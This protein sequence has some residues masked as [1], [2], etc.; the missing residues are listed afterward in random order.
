MHLTNLTEEEKT[1]IAPWQNTPIQFDKI[2]GHINKCTAIFSD[3]DLWV[4][5]TDSRIFEEKL[6]AKIL[7]EHNKNHICGDDNITE[8]PVILREVLEMTQ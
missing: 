8:L 6:N 4:P 5:I 2:T 3:N 7:I 1:T